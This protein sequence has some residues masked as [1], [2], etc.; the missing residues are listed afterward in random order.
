LNRINKMS[1]SRTFTSYVI[2]VLR[3]LS[4]LSITKDANLLLNQIL[5]KIVHIV[6]GTS[7]NLLQFSQR[8]T[9]N[10]KTLTNS[11]SLLFTGTLLENMLSEGGRTTRPLFPATFV[12]S[13]LKQHTTRPIS[14]KYVLFLSAILE[15]LTAELLDI[16]CF[17]AYAREPEIQFKAI[18][19]R[20]PSSNTK[21]DSLDLYYAI[22]SDVELNTFF[23]S[24]LKLVILSYPTTTLSEDDFI[25]MVKSACIKY[26]KPFHRMT[27]DALL[28]LQK[29]VEQII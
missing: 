20:L 9:L 27:K 29:Y 4:Y 14:N 19:W 18:Q 1:Y 28:L 2:K 5:F 26:D 15:Y 21:L 3:N 6:V 16:A 25:E 17:H 10:V 23:A 8:K 11:L 7:E 13:I 24:H 12:K 22:Q